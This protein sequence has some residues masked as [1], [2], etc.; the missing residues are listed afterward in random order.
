MFSR[1]LTLMHHRILSCVPEGE[2]VLLDTLLHRSGLRLDELVPPLADLCG[3]GRIVHQNQP[4]GKGG[5][6]H[7]YRRCPPGTRPE[8]S[9]VVEYDE[10]LHQR[11]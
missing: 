7:V 5:L 8:V 2:G 10:A 4:N 6:A 11:E 9:R 3:M 1:T